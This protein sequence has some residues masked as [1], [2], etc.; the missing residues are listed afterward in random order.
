DVR[1]GY[2]FPVLVGPA[3][4]L[5]LELRIV[6][7]GEHGARE[8]HGIAR[9]DEEPAA[10]GERFRRVEVAGRDDGF[11]GAEGVREGAAGDLVQVEIRRR[12]EVAREQVIDDLALR[13]V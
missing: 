1:P 12:V 8:T 13:E 4:E 7:D 10:V 6:E 2:L 11:S 3:L 9:L 5:P